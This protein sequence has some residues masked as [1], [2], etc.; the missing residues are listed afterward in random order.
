MVGVTFDIGPEGLTYLRR[1]VELA[2][3]AVE[4]G[5]EA[6]GSVLVGPDGEVL[7]EAHNEVG[8]GD[9][10]RH[11]ELVI[12]LWAAANLTV[13]DRAASTVYTSGEHC[14]MCSAA[15]AWAGLG[16]IA[17]AT[18]SA[19]LVAWRTSW[20]LPGSPVTP[21]PIGDIAPGLEVAGPVAELAD[22]VRALHA[23]VAGLTDAEAL[24]GTP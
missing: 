6:F 17:Y 14:P 18:S 9:G 5:H 7:L 11:P 16:P 3:T 10:T 1:C 4:A 12:A 23:R 2:A 8:G 20:K 19:Q 13:P 24:E 15:H 22:A 21:L